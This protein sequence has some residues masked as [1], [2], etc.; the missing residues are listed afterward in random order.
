MIFPDKILTLNNN[1][2]FNYK[3]L[4]EKDPSEN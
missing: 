4:T 3:I 2:K 1:L